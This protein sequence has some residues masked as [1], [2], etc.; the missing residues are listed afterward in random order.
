MSDILRGGEKRRPIC[1]TYWGGANMS[2][3]I[4]LTFWG[5][6]KTRGQYVRHFVSP[7]YEM[8]ETFGVYSI[9]KTKWNQTLKHLRLFVVTS[10]LSMGLTPSGI[11]GFRRGGPTGRSPGCG[12]KSGSWRN[13]G[14]HLERRLLC[15]PALETG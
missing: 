4:C 14:R 9:C 3:P 8:S 13:P 10:R 15:R 12:R 11:S 7:N 2:R 5:R 1:L 6:G